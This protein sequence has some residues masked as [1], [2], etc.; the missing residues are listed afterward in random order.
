MAAS[1][2]RLG[3]GSK[4]YTGDTASPID[5]TL[6]S[7]I[8]II[9][10]ADY[11]VAEVD[12][13][14]L[15]SPNTVPPGCGS[16]QAEIYFSDKYKPLTVAPEALIEPVIQDLRKCGLVKDDDEIAHKSAWVT[17]GNVIFDHDRPVSL[18]KVHAYLSELGIRYCGRYG[19]WGYMWTDE[20]FFS[21]ERAAQDLL[22]HLA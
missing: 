16:I 3:Y 14:H 6:L 4:F 22:D 11:T 17:S 2:A 9:N 20:S 10:F 5:Y 15:L 7:E 8:A 19:D 12:V 13:T 18:P 1:K 21:G